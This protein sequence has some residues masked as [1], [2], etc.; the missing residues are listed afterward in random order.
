[1][2]LPNRQFM[3]P[4]FR[5]LAERGRWDELMDRA[6]SW[7]DAQMSYAQIGYVLFRAAKHTGRHQ[8]ILDAIEAL[9]GWEGRADLVRLRAN[10][11]YDR[12]ETLP[13]IERL[14]RDPT[15]AGN[16]MLRRK[17]EIKREVLARAMAHA[18]RRAIFLCT[19]RNYLAA[20]FVAP[21]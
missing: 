11:E 19:D 13:T 3:L 17:L 16:D 20:T 6:L 8:D 1:M 12:A 15:I 2:E 14:A 10:L 9:E 21:A 4:V 18:S 7:L 5:Y